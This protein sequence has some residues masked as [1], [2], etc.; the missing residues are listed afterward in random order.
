MRALVLT[1]L[2]LG[3]CGSAHATAHSLT[4]AR[5]GVTFFRTTP[6]NA[7]YEAKECVRH[8]LVRCGNFITRGD[9]RA[10]ASDCRGRH[11]ARALRVAARRA[12][13]RGPRWRVVTSTAAGGYPYSCRFGVVRLSER[14]RVRAAVRGARSRV[15]APRG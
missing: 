13:A 12:W 6:Q 8:G 5:G 1:I 2:A 7:V 9:G 10:F 14:P 4:Y 11:V 3:A 15:S